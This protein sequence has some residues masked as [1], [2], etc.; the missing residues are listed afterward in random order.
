[1]KREK[2]FGLSPRIARW[3]IDTPFENWLGAKAESSIFW[4]K[5]YLLFY[6]I[7]DHQYYK[8]GKEMARNAIANHISGQNITNIDSVV[9]DMI[10]C[11]HKYGYSFQDYCIYEFAFNQDVRYRESFVA[12]K[13][14]YH[15]CDILNAPNIME[16][17]TN[18][19]SCYK[20]YKQFYKRELIGCLSNGDKD[21]FIDFASRHNKFIYKPLGEH[22]GR[23]VEIY[24]VENH[25]LLDFFNEKLSHGAFVLEELIVQGEET[26]RM[27]PKSINSCRVLS[28][29]N[30][31]KVDIIGT[32]WRVG[33]GGSIKDNA[34]AGGMYAYINPKT[35]VVESDAINYKGMHYKTHP[36]T[37]LSF[38]GYQM[39]AW[40]EAIALINKMAVNIA[41]TTLI[42]WDI[43]YSNNGWVM[44]EA[45]ENGD[46]SIIQ[47][48]KKIGF[49]KLL[50]Y[51]M[52]LFFNTK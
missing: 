9:D 48:N 7:F 18:K 49:K 29:T 21:I 19:L 39:P 36:D 43:A 45:N 40:N 8:C 47:S 26:A 20:Y 27:H 34:G 33:T 35:G 51:Y 13:L 2:Y 10:F 4:R 3:K 44:V 46:W 14:R 17:L 23:G 52:D 50:F 24:D 37:A 31:G 25:N 6:N 42:A 16:M 28:F 32:T 41:G 15:Y 12:D 1:M 5:V 22:S 11:L 38:E 30:N